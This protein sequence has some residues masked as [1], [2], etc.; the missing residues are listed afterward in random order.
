MWW[1]GIVCV[2]ATIVQSSYA[3]AQNVKPDDVCV[4]VEGQQTK[5]VSKQ[6]LALALLTQNSDAMKLYLDVQRVGASVPSPEWQSI[7]TAGP[8][9]CKNNAACLAPN[10]KKVDDTAAQATLLNLGT[11]LRS[12]LIEAGSDPISGYSTATPDIGTKYLVGAD[13]V[14]PVKCIGPGPQPVAKAPPGISGGP[15]RLRLSADDLNIS[16]SDKDAFKG[17]KPATASYTRDGVANKTSF[18]GQGALGYAFSL[19]D[20]AEVVPYVAAIQS[21]SKVDGK[22]ATYGDTNNWAAGALFDGI[23]SYSNDYIAV[24]NVFMAKPQYLW[25]TKDRSEIASVQFRWQ[26]WTQDVAQKTPSPG[27]IPPPIINS[28]F[29]LGPDQAQLL[30]DLRFNSGTYTNKGNDPMTA[31]QHISY[32]RGGSNFGFAIATPS[33]LGPY[34]TLNVTETLLDGFAGQVHYI[35]LFQA[36][37]AYYFDSTGNVGVSAQYKNG[38][39]EDTAEYAQTYTIGLSAKF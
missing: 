16:S 21:Y 18:S 22:A 17:L 38:R 33:A 36:T 27:Y 8:D 15:F 35:S 34:A 20:N 13:T 14:N 5:I 19:T 37:L 28:V 26:P 12:F 31:V 9:F 10:G 4:R 3:L 6:K 32:A 30:F 11:A 39:D 2:A 25:N 24:T 7:F 23:S 29:P 1:R